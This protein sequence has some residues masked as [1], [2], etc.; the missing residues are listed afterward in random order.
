MTDGGEA[1]PTAGALVA[2]SWT[3]EERAHIE[4][5]LELAGRAAGEGEVPVGALVVLDG[6]VIGEG[7]NRPIGA[8][9]PSAHAEIEALRAAARR[10]GNYRLPGSTLYV[11]LEPCVMCAGAIIHA[12]VAR[13]VY[14]A[15]DPKAGACGSVFDLLPSDGRF[16]HRTECSGGLLAERCGEILR[17]FFRARR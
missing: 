9:D 15:S 6:E 4:R 3:A 16:N 17:A 8:A 14:G 12:R 10:V 2:G 11:T 7:W 5:A 1:I 13:V